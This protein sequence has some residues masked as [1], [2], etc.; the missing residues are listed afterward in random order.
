MKKYIKPTLNVRII[1]ASALLAGSLESVNGEY[2]GTL[3][4][5]AKDSFAD[6]LDEEY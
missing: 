2:D 6:E 4:L 5:K 1:A 3:P